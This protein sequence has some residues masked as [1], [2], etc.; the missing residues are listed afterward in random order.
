M[1]SIKLHKVT[2]LPLLRSSKLWIPRILIWCGVFLVACLVSTALCSGIALSALKQHRFTLAQKT[3][4]IGQYPAAILAGI[5]AHRIPDLTAWQLALKLTAEIS[6]QATA[7]TPTTAA[8]LQPLAQSFATL[9]ELLPQTYLLRQLL[10][11]SAHG[12]LAALSPLVTASPE[13]LNTLAAGTQTWLILLENNDELRAT[14]GFM[15]S[16]ALVTLEN[17]ALTNLV[18][19]DIYDADGQFEGFVP[20]PPGAYE[21]LSGGNGLRLPDSNWSPDFPTS[22]EQ[23]LQFFALGKRTALSGVIA[24]N[25]EIIR[26]LLTIVGPLQLPDYPEAVTAITLDAVLRT[27]REPFFP[28]SIQKKHLLTQAFTQLKLKLGTLSLQQ[29]Q[30]SA[31]VVTNRL[32]TKDIQVYALEPTLEAL[33]DS[34]HITGRVTTIPGVYNQSATEETTQATATSAPPPPELPLP[35]L[36]PATEPDFYF[37]PVESNVGINK[38]NAGITRSYEVTLAPAATTLS[39]TWHNQN[40]PSGSSFDPAALGA[41]NSASFRTSM[42]TN[43]RAATTQ[44][45]LS[46]ASAT[47]L[48]YVNYFRLVLPPETIVEHIQFDAT[49]ITNWD[50]DTITTA[51]GARFLQLGVLVIVPEQS[52]GLLQITLANPAPLQ[53]KLYD[54]SPVTLTIQKQSGTGTIPLKLT[55]PTTTR[56]LLLTHDTS[57]TTLGQ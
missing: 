37:F 34:L 18:I 4:Q 36:P 39:I 33:L 54:G 10:P 52:L 13:L 50:A 21:Y 20:A 45:P 3:A 17:G 46:S 47:H 29:L 32:A 1:C 23:V 7:Q 56:D 31:R 25:Q 27:N 14:G 9:V 40:Q 44:A 51:N 24:L 30:D 8:T 43:S 11:S 38:A 22:A 57:V 53:A 16:Y 26:D 35:A 15:G 6:A 28:G 42:L 48:A 41:T 49:E 55:T 12:T 19:E 2:P 5:T